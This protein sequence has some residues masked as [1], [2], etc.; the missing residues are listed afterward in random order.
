MNFQR[1][2]GSIMTVSKMQQIQLQPA[3]WWQNTLKD[4][5][6]QQVMIYGS[7]NIQDMHG[8]G[9]NGQIHVTFISLTLTK[10]RVMHLYI[11]T[12]MQEWSK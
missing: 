6:M 11:T 5:L 12:N 3:I 2:L 8:Q 10:E 4:A 1:R 7:K 9:L